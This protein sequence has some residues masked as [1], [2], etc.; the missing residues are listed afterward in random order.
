MD[1]TL[2][3]AIATLLAL[4]VLVLASVW[5]AR[6]RA[7]RAAEIV[8]KSEAYDRWL[9]AQRD[10]HFPLGAVVEMRRP[11]NVRVGPKLR[12]QPGR[13]LQNRTQD[14]APVPTLFEN[15]AVADMIALERE[16]AAPAPAAEFHGGGGDF[17][18][19]GASGGWDSSPSAPDTGSSSTDSSPSSTDF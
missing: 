12:T 6:R 1:T 11:S 8:E 15:Q 19:A 13:T 7:R 17:G 2:I 10:E 3:V 4:V 16:A 5:I 18:G 14:D 9:A